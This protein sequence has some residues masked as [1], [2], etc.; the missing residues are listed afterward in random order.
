MFYRNKELPY[1]EARIAINSDACYK[2]HFH[3]SLSIGAVFEG[4]SEFTCSGKKYPLEVRQL[5]VINPRE[6]HCCN[7][8]A[9]QSR[10]YCLIYLD[11]KWCKKIQNQI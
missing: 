5:A 9:N 11:E 3:Q 8:K 2:D 6:I 10:S 7:P 4:K 1:L